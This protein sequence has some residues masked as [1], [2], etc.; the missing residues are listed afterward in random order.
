MLHIGFER[1]GI[2]ALAF[3]SIF[4][5]CFIFNAISMST[6]LRDGVSASS[7]FGGIPLWPSDDDFA[8]SK[9]IEYRRLSKKYLALFLASAIVTGIG[10]LI[11]QHFA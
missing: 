3:A 9:G 8:D 5:L 10:F 11:S 1:L 2:A 6:C 7:S 4:L